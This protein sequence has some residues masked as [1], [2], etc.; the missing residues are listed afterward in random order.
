M[1]NIK[2]LFACL[3]L[4]TIAACAS[5]T[6]TPPA[7]PT[8]A[9]HLERHEV[10][11]ALLWMQRSLEFRVST[12][13]IYRDATNKLATALSKPGTAAAE[14][15]SQT[16]YASLPPAVIVDID[17]TVLDNS[18]YQA[19]RM[20]TD[21]EFEPATWSGWVRR[22]AATAIP[23]ALE[24]AQNAQRAGA[25]VIYIS[26]RDCEK[27]APA[28]CREK[29][30][31]I[32]N[33]KR[34]G[35]PVID[36]GDVMFRGERAGWIGKESRR[37]EAGSRYR[38]VMMIGDDM[39]DL[40]PAAMVMDLRKSASE[41]LHAAH[42]AKIG[43]RLFLLPNPAYGQWEDLIG[44]ERCKTGDRACASRVLKRKFDALDAFEPAPR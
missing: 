40:L 5:L 8:Q 34:L 36:D 3:P 17:E 31:T 32:G 10:L 43:E 9:V 23:G 11:N 19:W 41:N 30:A 38:I 21:S 14:Q 13:Q 39:R 18:R 6:E 35:F 15:E 7:Q 42:T 33:L 16:G 25:R 29:E 24:F 20:K 37:A 2:K 28:A 27:P 26:N 1:P 22:G 44:S 12:Q 4:F